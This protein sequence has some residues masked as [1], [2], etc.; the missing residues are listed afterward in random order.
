MLIPVGYERLFKNG[1]IVGLGYLP[2]LRK[3][4]LVFLF[5]SDTSP[6]E[7]EHTVV[8]ILSDTSTGSHANNLYNADEAYARIF[9]L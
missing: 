7:P 4:E 8:Q 9:I 5:Y 6:S 1:M 2:L 3:C